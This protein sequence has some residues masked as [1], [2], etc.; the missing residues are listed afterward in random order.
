L[1]KEIYNCA[2]QCGFDNCG[3]I[4]VNAL[5]GFEELYQKRISDVPQ[6]KFFYDN[7]GDLQ[8]TKER[9]PWA[10]SIVILT[11]NYGKY[12]YP[13]ELQGKYAKAFFLQPHKNSDFGF[14]L[15]RFE[16]WFVEHEIHAEGGEQFH[17]HSV[18]PLRYIAAKAGLGI[19]RKNN[20]FYTE[21]GSY[22]MLIGYVIDKEYELI[23]NTHVIPCGEKCDLCQRACKTKALQS[24]YTIDPLKCVSY[25]TTFGNSD[26]PQGLSPEM[27]EEWVCGCDNCQDACP[28]NIRHDWNA[29]KHFSN[30]KEIAPMILPRNYENLSDEFLIEQVISKTADHL[31]VSD[32]QALR[33]NAERSLNY[34]QIKPKN[35]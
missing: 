11:F 12:C 34:Q 33:K 27:F 14:D 23:Q 13:K 8:G 24:Q 17:H 5:N 1:S 2:I 19:I 9:F 18:G 4:S 6:S 35:K 7:V 28:H 16:Q 29:G 30:L 21:N 26:I 15:Q 32:V 31:Q 22:N 10:K 25:W 3:I 20:F